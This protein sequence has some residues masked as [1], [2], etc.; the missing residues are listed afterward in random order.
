M[1][2]PCYVVIYDEFATVC[3]EDLRCCLVQKM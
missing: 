3:P 2:E 1:M